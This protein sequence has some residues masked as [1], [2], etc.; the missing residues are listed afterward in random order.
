MLLASR[1]AEKRQFESDHER[2]R[3]RYIAGHT[4]TAFPPGTYGYRVLLGVRVGR[5][6][7]AA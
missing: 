7:A 2:A 3:R 5:D 1:I 6:G 4:R